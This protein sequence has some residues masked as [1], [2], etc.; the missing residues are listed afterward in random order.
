MK[1]STF[2]LAFLCLLLPLLAW[3]QGKPSQSNY[4]PVLLSGNGAPVGNCT[5]INY[6]YLNTTPGNGNLYT[7]PVPGSA[8]VLSG[9]GSGTPYSWFGNTMNPLTA[10]V[11]PTTIA[12]ADGNTLPFS[13]A[14]IG[15]FDTPV[16]SSSDG[17]IANSLINALICAD[18][19]GDSIELSAGV[20]TY[21]DVAGDICSLNSG[22][23][24][25]VAASGDK[26]VAGPSGINIQST[27]GICVSDAG[28]CSLTAGITKIAGSSEVDVGI[29]TGDNVVIKGTTT[30][31]D[32]TGTQFGSPT[33]G[34]Q[35]P[36]TF[37]AQGCFVNGVACLTSLPFPLLIGSAFNTT[38]Y[39]NATTGLTTI[40]TSPS[41][42]AG[43]LVYVDCQGTY[44]ITGT[45]EKIGI[46]LTASQTAQNMDYGAFINYSAA[47]GVGSVG[48]SGTSTTGGTAISGG[49]VVGSTGAVYAFRISGRILWNATTAGTV[50]LQ[51]ET[52]NAL[53][54]VTINAYNTSCLFTRLQ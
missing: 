42:A 37:N 17:C 20:I 54:T 12:D 18:K 40:V 41:I 49:G 11:D 35:G 7:C 21:T 9:G 48:F 5:G 10:L 4:P 8:W 39:T 52:G 25:C 22:A 1:K 27:N 46:A 26:I 14:G 32:S 45:A 28:G 31:N 13:S 15:F 44:S 36:G 19:A 23:I 6:F 50:A 33:G 34:P 29:S 47:A 38:Q 3:G 2:F 24:S 16:S 43:W 53:G 30:I 51:A